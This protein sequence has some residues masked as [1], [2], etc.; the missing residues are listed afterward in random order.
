MDRMGNRPQLTS[1]AMWL[2]VTAVTAG[3]ATTP[4]GA[5]AAFRLE[6]AP[7]DP[8]AP[9][10]RPLPL[11]KT[12]FLIKDPRLGVQPPPRGPV[13]LLLLVDTLGRVTE[14]KVETSSGQRSLDQ[15]AIRGAR[16]LEFR[17]ATVNC[18]PVEMWTP[19][20]HARMEKGPVW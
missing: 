7:C 15:A 10:D 18:E 14:V 16:R 4:P 8:Q 1:A 11:P 9:T 19:L 2:G 3:C 13:D 6:E 12:I 17:P 5:D 20:A